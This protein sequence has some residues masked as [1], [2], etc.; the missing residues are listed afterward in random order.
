V[1]FWWA[2]GWVYMCV[3]F[4]VVGVGLV[5]GKSFKD[6]RGQAD[7]PQVAHGASC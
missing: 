2:V 7:P 5:S 3:G 4:G 1:V 6:V